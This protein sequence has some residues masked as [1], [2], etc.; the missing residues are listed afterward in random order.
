MRERWNRK[1]AIE[2]MTSVNKGKQRIWKPHTKPI[3]LCFDAHPHTHTHRVKRDKG[4]SVDMASTYCTVGTRAATQSLPMSIIIRRSGC[5][6]APSRAQ[7]KR[8]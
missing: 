8:V 6:C 4:Q 2:S 7:L 1:A 3:N 5:K